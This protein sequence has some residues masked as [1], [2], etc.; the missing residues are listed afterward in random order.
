VI[1]SH[2]FTFNPFEENTYILSDE[3]GEC[4]ILDPGC[5]EQNEKEKLSRFIEDAGLK[6]VRILLTHAHIDHILGNNFVAGKYHI[7]I[8][9]SR[10]EIALLQA[11]PQ[12]GQMWGV[13]TEPSPEPEF[14]VDE[15]DE[16]RFGNSSLK[17]IFTPGHSPGSFSY[18]DP[19]TQSLFSG[20]VLFLESIGRTD[21]PGG[22]FNTLIQSIKEKLFLLP[23]ATKVFPGHGPVTTIGYEKK[24]NPFL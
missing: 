10:K 11:A 22:D 15:A 12:Y 2:I 13:E 19:E 9:M 3:T 18:Y 1:S 7:P 21:L 5:Y 23:E 24:H 8:Q 20:D 16:I 6:P 4:I 17:V 14:F